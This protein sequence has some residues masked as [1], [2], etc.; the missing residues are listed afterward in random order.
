MDIRPAATLVLTRDTENGIEVLL[1]Q[2]TWEAIFLPGYYV[3]PGGAVNEQESEA[4]PHVVG[5]EDADISQTMSLDEGGADFMLAAV[6]ECF[7][8]AGVLLAQDGSGQLIGADHPVL[9]ERQALF[10]DEV[11]LAQLCEKHGLVV[12]LDR[13]AYLSHWV[14]PPGPPR[15]FDTR[16]FVAVAPE[17]QRAGHDGQ[18]TIDHVWISP[19]QALEEHRAGQRLLGLPTIRTL[20]VLCDFSSTAELMRY[21]HANPPEAFPTDPWPALRKGKPVMLEPNAPAYD[22]AVKLDPEG[23]GTTRAEIVPGELVEVAAGV[24]RLTAPNP[25]MMTG[26][27]TN[28]YILGFE[29]FTVI[30]PGPANEAHIEKILEVT[31]GVV[32]QVLVTHTH[33]DHSPAVLELKQ[34]TGCRVFGW[35]A[36]E[37]AGQDQSFKADDEPEHGDLIVS[38]AGILK[39][40]HTPGHASNHLCFLL[41]DQELLF[42]GDHIMQ[43]ST[44]VINPPDGD[45]KAYVESLY[46]LLDEAIRFIAPAHGFLMGQPEAVIDYLITHRLSREHKIFRSLQALAPVSLKDLTAKAYDDVPAAIHGLAARSALAHLLKLEAEQRAYQS[47]N[48][49]HTH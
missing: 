1:L 5:V 2:R 30:D 48:L 47:D 15:R 7:E 9:G 8:E 31:G 23:E 11:S 44:V 43:G 22:E 45:M 37:G 14:T 6:R 40:I 26:P 32:D 10:R 49:W 42:S 17:G 38:E 29:R 28:T 18:E 21:A 36:P 16:F 27:G 24:V 20:R 4:Q 25:G 12:P 35:P 33:L 3:F 41:T 13:L 46:E 34:R 19:A 39:V